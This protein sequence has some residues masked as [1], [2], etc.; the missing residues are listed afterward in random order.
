MLFEMIHTEF[1]IKWNYQLHVQRH[2][3]LEQQVIPHEPY[4]LQ[5]LDPQ[6]DYYQ[7]TG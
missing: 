6:E 1:M 3:I 2:N 7:R 4:Q 5:E